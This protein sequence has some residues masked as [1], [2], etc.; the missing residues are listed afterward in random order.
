ME[1]IT[2]QILERGIKRRALVAWRTINTLDYQSAQLQQ[3]HCRDEHR[4]CARLH[5][6]TSTLVPVRLRTLPVS[7]R[8][9]FEKYS[10]PPNVSNTRG[11]KNILPYESETSAGSK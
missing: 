5:A 2:P 3:L 6:R 10:H 9:G 11:R 1:N 4:L 8:S 7:F